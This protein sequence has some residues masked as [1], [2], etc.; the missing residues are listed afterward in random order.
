MNNLL[1]ARLIGSKW[2]LKYSTRLNGTSLKTLIRKCENSET[3]NLVIIKVSHARALRTSRPNQRP[4]CVFRPVAIQL[5]VVYHLVVSVYRNTSLVLE[6][7]SY[8]V[9]KITTNQV[10]SHS[11]FQ[12][13]RSWEDSWLIMDGTV[14]G[15]IRFSPP[16]PSN[17]MTV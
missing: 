4:K 2:N 14:V 11:Y 9:L 6:N 8:S 7:P 1:P 10:N 17:F 3:P 13:G 16:R 15:H 5:L 12:I